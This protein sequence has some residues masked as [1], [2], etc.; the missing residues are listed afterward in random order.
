[1]AIVPE[2]RKSYGGKEMK[3]PNCTW[4]CACEFHSAQYD[5]LDYELTSV[6]IAQGMAKKAN[7]RIEDG[8]KDAEEWAEGYVITWSDKLICILAVLFFFWL[9]N[10]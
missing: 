8:V 10:Q 4:L 7:K 1:M 3:C 2:L 6:Q 5:R 9:A